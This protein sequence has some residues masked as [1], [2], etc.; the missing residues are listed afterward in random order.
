M[1]TLKQIYTAPPKHWVGNG[2]HV[3]PLF[4]HMGEPKQTSPF[5]MLDY[6]APMEFA[7]NTAHPRGVS[8]H[9][10]RGFETVTIAYQGEV[11]HRDGSGATGV[12]KRGDVQWMT[13]GSGTVHEE[14][15]SQA[16][17]ERGGWFEMAQI[18]VNLPKA[19]KSAPPR[20][21]HLQNDAIPVVKL[22][23]G[24]IRIIGGEYN[25]VRG[26][27]EIFSELNIWDI[28]VDVD[29]EMVF[30]LPETHNV[31]IVVRRSNVLFNGKHTARATDLAIFE[32]ENGEISVRNQGDETAELL[33]LS[34]VPIDEPIAAYGP[35]V[36]NTPEEIR[37]S[38]EAY[39][40][41]EYGSLNSL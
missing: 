29:A 35:F 10:H 17:S 41:G 15:H 2:F 26:A 13:A 3:S 4:S 23:G 20:Y 22:D 28:S 38:I 9:P 37:E 14:F 32:R 39:R 12:I 34:G 19:H 8:E 33:V 5:L 18:W 21:Q 31:S 40:R 30:R 36:M 24:S 11:A 1:R 6:A 7:P 16:F 25:G 27:G